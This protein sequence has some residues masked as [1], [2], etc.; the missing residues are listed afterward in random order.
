MLYSYTP[1]KHKKTS[2]FL[3]F[4]GGKGM[5]H[6]REIGLVIYLLQ[7]GNLLIGISSIVSYLC[8]FDC[9][10]NNINRLIHTIPK[11]SHAL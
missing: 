7:S 6:W 5:E 4:S 3:A 10:K 2:G 11:W 9:K 1:W 8:S